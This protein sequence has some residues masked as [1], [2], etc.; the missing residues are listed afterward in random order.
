[1]ADD[2]G[3]PSLS[4]PPEL[5]ADWLELCAV[6][7][8]DVCTSLADIQS[9]LTVSGTAD[10]VDD[11]DGSGP[12]LGDAD[13]YEAAAEA[14]F[15]EIDDRSV[16]C[17]CDDLGYPFEID[18]TSLVA[19]SGS[20]ESVYV[21]LLLLSKYGHATRI[22]GDNGA[23]LFEEVC[24]QAAAAYLGG[25]HSHVASFVF[26]FPRRTAPGGFACAV[27]SLC[28]QLREGGGN[29]ARPRTK[30][31]KDAKLDIVAWRAFADSRGG[32]L[33]AFGQC[34]TGSDWPDKVH[35]LGAPA[36]WCKLWMREELAVDPLKMFFVP[37][38]VP[39]DRWLE[40]CVG[41]GILFDRCRIVQHSCHLD[42]ALRQRI[43]TWS[44]TVMAHNVQ[45]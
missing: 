34:A 35:E 9:A 7:D 5:K 17:D 11:E 18:S 27:D 23:K 44:A 32:K 16:S 30:D 26:G 29:R 45:T 21:F 6:R 19:V 38:R 33:I 8:T 40:T 1:M 28:D 41:G 25:P 4:D 12:T 13:R 43:A 37:H 22:N 14:A 42:D 24:A 39:G 3:V 20:M 15:F 10:A 2:A 36:G 31:Q